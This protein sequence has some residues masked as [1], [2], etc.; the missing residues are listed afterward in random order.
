MAAASA[1]A[2]K[3]VYICGSKWKNIY[4]CSVGLEL[5]PAQPWGLPVT[6]Q[7]AI[8]APPHVWT[9]LLRHMCKRDLS[10][11]PLSLFLLTSPCSHILSKTDEIIASFPG[12]QWGQVGE[13]GLEHTACAV[14]HKFKSQH[15]ATYTRFGWVSLI[16]DSRRAKAIACSWAQYTV[17]KMCGELVSSNRLFVQQ[18]W[19]AVGIRVSKSD[20]L[21]GCTG[22]HTSS[23]QAPV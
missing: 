7:T 3:C 13:K 21:P 19:L 18:T 5:S 9:L 14:A 10:L 23:S 16:L 8:C 11:C 15:Y 2:Q 17:C 20:C 22:Q 1:E 4:N 6:R 12:V